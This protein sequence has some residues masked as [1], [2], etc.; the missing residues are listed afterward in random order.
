MKSECPKPIEFLQKKKHPIRNCA[1]HDKH[2]QACGAEQHELVC[3][4]GIYILG[5]EGMVGKKGHFFGSYGGGERHSRDGQILRPW[6]FLHTASM[7]KD[8]TGDQ[9]GGG[10]IQNSVISFF[11][12]IVVGR[13]VLTDG[14]V[15][16][17]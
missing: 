6:T 4:D 15:R 10:T 5:S 1:E 3:A 9:K 12:T 14:L 7:K 13:G 11:P 2:F 8:I 16:P 17:S